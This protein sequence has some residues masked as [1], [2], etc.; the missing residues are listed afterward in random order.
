MDSELPLPEP[1][2][3]PETARGRRAAIAGGLV[4][5]LLAAAIG[6][7]VLVAGGDDP[8]ELRALP[9]LS[10]A[11]DTAGGATERDSMLALPA[12]YRLAGELPDLPSSA[13][14]WQLRAATS[15]EDA[16]RRVARALGVEGDVQTTDGGAVVSDDSHTVNVSPGAGLQVSSY[17]GPS[18]G[19][20]YPDGGWAGGGSSGSSG[21]AEKST[22][23]ITREESFTGSTTVVPSLP[24]EPTALPSAAEAEDIA[25]ELL[26]RIGVLEGSDWDAEVTDGGNVGVATAACDSS[27][28][29]ADIPGRTAVVT[30]RSVVLHRLVD[31]ARI[32]GLEWYVEVGDRGDVQSISGNWAT[33]EPIGDYP[34]RSVAAGFDALKTEDARDIALVDPAADSALVDPAPGPEPEAVV[35]TVTGASLAHEL[36]YTGVVTEN[37]AYVVP[38]FHFVGTSSAGGDWAR[39]VLALADEYVTTPD[40]TAVVEPG[41]TEPAPVPEAPAST[42]ASEPGVA[43]ATLFVYVSNQSFAVDPVDIA[44][45]LDDEQLVAEDFLVGSQHSWKTFEF[46]AK[47]GAHEIG[48]SSQ[49]G[50][51]DAG[52]SL[53]LVPGANYVVVSFW[54]DGSA[55]GSEFSITTHAEPPAFD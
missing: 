1:E 2:P 22:D 35:V 9:L 48:A 34:L 42:P 50:G 21:A 44:I 17:R 41:P 36:R 5:V 40:T 43:E 39:D 37:A 6:V 18:G 11:S 26:A 4:V 32:T 13:P 52:M 49:R 20:A 51:A 53:D 12:E 3:V 46:P 23:E 28:K 19:I 45:S 55:S 15:A 33:L 47:P 54:N 27:G 10:A 30:S 16:A 25:R 31:G 38:V 8:D 14:V 24:A 7:G 29:C